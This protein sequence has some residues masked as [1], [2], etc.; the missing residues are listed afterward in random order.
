MLKM[1]HTVQEKDPTK[2]VLKKVNIYIYI[3]I[4]ICIYNIENI[5]K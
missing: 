4:Y 2:N 1:L 5:S 3:Y